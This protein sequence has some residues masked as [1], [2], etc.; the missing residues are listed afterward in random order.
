[1]V[2]VARVVRE[3]PKFQWR[4][5]NRR[6]VTGRYHLRGSQ[7][8]VHVRHGTPDL[9]GLVELFV[10]RIHDLPD[11][12]AELL[13]RHAHGRELR[14]VD[15]G[16]NI[17]LF[18]LRA[19]QRFP[20]AEVISFEPDPANAQLLRLTAEANGSFERWQ[21]I[22]ACAGSK[23]AEVQFVAGRYLESRIAGKDDVSATPLPKVD[24]FPYLER[25]DWVKIDIEGAEWEILAD[26]RFLDLDIPVLRLEYH[27]H[28]C[29]ADSPRTLA[30]KALTDAGYRIE[31][32]QERAPGL[33]EL[34]AWR[35]DGT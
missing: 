20:D 14:I 31:P 19:L 26:Q 10:M 13:A 25:A 22:N 29:P 33:G 15:L 6:I 12:L 34:W 35:P 28:L 7:L 21:L 32:F 16:G 27:P 23:T 5:V 4:E 24:V 9:G 17:G 11:P 1:M 3:S 8:I 2:R 30:I 18:A